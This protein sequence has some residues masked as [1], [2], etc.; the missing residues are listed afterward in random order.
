MSTGIHYTPGSLPSLFANDAAA[1]NEF[2]QPILGLDTKDG[3]WDILRGLPY[4]NMDLSIKKNFK[5]TE[6]VNFEFQ[7]VFINVL[8]HTVFDDPGPGDYLDTSAGPDGFG[9]LP[10][11][12]NIPRT[13]EFGFRVSF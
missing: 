1:Y 9:T 12:G 7:T 5:I 10:K 2:R 6:R 11:Q 4:W 13:M 3:G 8:N